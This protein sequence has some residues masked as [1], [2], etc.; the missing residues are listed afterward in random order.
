M[1]MKE[2]RKQ[3]KEKFLQEN[4]G[5]AKKL[6]GVIKQ[7]YMPQRGLQTYMFAYCFDPEIVMGD[8]INCFGHAVFNLTNE[9][10]VKLGLT[11]E[12][13][14]PMWRFGEKQAQG[15][16]FTD[17]IED[18]VRQTGLKIEPCE[19]HTKMK[20]NQWKIAYYM[21]HPAEG[22]DYHFI[23]QERDGRWSSKNGQRP[24]VETFVSDPPKMWKDKYY[25]CGYYCITNP[26]VNEFTGKPI[27]ENENASKTNDGGMTK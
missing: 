20:K 16:K 21:R 10:I 23:L 25:L 22:L 17:E 27:F 4:V 26:Y 13:I 1:R 9:M 7:G 3:K 24:K 11:M 15:I 12:E 6:G 2:L 14:E 8:I 18:F 19:L 5:L